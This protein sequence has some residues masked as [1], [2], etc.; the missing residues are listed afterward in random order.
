MIEPVGLSSL[1]SSHTP[2]N[3]HSYQGA[4]I[5]AQTTKS[6]VEP[7]GQLCHSHENVLPE[8]VGR[9]ESLFSDAGSATSAKE[10]TPVTSNKHSTKKKARIHFAG[11]AGVT[12]LGIVLAPLTAGM[13]MFPAMLIAMYGNAAFVSTY[14]GS[15]FDAGDRD[16]NQKPTKPGTDDTKGK[17]PETSRPHKGLTVDS[18]ADTR[19]LKDA[20]SVLITDSNNITNSFNTSIF[21]LTAPTDEDVAAEGRETPAPVLI[22]TCLQR[23]SLEYRAKKQPF[24]QVDRV[25]LTEKQFIDE[26]Q[27]AS[28]NGY[29]CAEN[30]GDILHQ[31]ENVSGEI[32][33]QRAT[34]KAGNVHATAYAVKIDDQ[35]A[36]PASASIPTYTQP[37]IPTYTQPSISIP[38]SAQTLNPRVADASDVADGHRSVPLSYGDEPEISVEPAAVINFPPSTQDNATLTPTAPT[39]SKPGDDAVDS[40]KG[41]STISTSGSSKIRPTATPLHRVTLTNGSFGKTVMATQGDNATRDSEFD[42]A[43]RSSTKNMTV[44][45]TK[46]PASAQTLNPRVTD[47][48]SDVA[49]GHRSVPLSYGDEPEISVE[50]AA[51]INFPPSTQDNA[52]LTPT[53]PTLS[54][55]G[56]DAVDS[57]KGSST[58]STSGSSKIR[59]TATPLHRVTMTNG[60]FGKTVM[61][62]QGNTIPHSNFNRDEMHKHRNDMASFLDST[63][64]NNSKT[65]FERLGVGVQPAKV[66]TMVAA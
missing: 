35:Q 24:T 12:T 21:F 3:R 16:D 40:G 60:F 14:G 28:D 34:F 48:A 61:A 53:A 66:S 36:P 1:T 65:R 10:K 41:S 26:M 20:P 47:D 4:N 37:S 58:I 22:E 64:R 30:L 39:L 25:V 11:L 38:T 54:K 5:S 63:I 55:P 62:T 29:Q 15:H 50:P 2:S 44:S 56:D 59:P 49:D 7:T 9:T 57:G 17:T 45:S 19:D 42:P 13:S 23:E 18:G 31:L 27:K 33:I 52:T 32:A 6:M 8:Y 43:V 51:V 46:R